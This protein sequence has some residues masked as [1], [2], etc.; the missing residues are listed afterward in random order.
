MFMRL[1]YFNADS[2]TSATK[3]GSNWYIFSNCLD[4]LTLNADYEQI[5]FVNYIFCAVC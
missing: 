4:I 3:Q 5:E 1:E 2:S